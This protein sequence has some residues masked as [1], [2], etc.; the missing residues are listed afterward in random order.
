MC[1]VHIKVYPEIGEV[2][3]VYFRV[4]ATADLDLLELEILDWVTDNLI[5]ATKYDILSCK[6]VL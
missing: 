2:Y 4:R 5:N 1:K 3:D 6:A